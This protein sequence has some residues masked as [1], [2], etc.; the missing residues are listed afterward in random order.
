MARQHFKGILSKRWQ[1]RS[2]NKPSLYSKFFVM[3]Y[4]AAK[5]SGHLELISSQGSHQAE[6]ECNLI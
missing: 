1:R 2:E 4:N 3:G 6:Y 5:S